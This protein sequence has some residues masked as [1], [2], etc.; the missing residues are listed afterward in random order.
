MKKRNG[1]GIIYKPV[2]TNGNISAKAKAM[3]AY[4][5]C[6]GENIYPSRDTVIKELHISKTSYYKYLDELVSSGVVSIKKK[7]FGRNTY[8]LK[9]WDKSAGYGIMPRR[10]AMDGK[11]SMTAKSIYACISVFAGAAGTAF[12]SASL[13]ISQ[14]GISESTF[15]THFRSLLSYGFID[16][17]SVKK[18]GRYASNRYKINFLDVI[19]TP[20]EDKKLHSEKQYTK[21][22]D[23]EKWDKYIN[24]NSYKINSN[25]INHNESEIR[26]DGSVK[27]CIKSKL[28]ESLERLEKYFFSLPTKEKTIK[29]GRSEYRAEDIKKC[30]ASCK[31]WKLKHIEKAI[32]RTGSKIKYLDRYL[33]ACLMNFGNGTSTPEKSETKTKQPSSY[34][35]NAYNELL[36]TNAELMKKYGHLLTAEGC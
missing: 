16:V 1:Y 12:P 34:D 18:D 26:E 2:I 15:Y 7:L 33:L 25:N 32:R 3:Y 19:E 30:L 24:I 9:K 20:K 27:P 23:T 11:I 6:Y 28:A 31:P 4:L 17:V 21:N 22:W 13:I 10:V 35:L 8:I 5:A 29:V 36:L 14:L